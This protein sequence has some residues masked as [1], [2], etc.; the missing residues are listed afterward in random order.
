MAAPYEDEAASAPPTASWHQELIAPFG[1][2]LREQLPWQ[3]TS[4]LP[5]T[6]GQGVPMEDQER[7]LPSISPLRM[8]TDLRRKLGR[9]A[10]YNLRLLI[11][12][13]LHT[14]KTQLWR[15]LQ[16][17]SFGH[18]LPTTR[19]L[20]TVHLD[21]SSERSPDVV[22]VEAWDVVDADLTRSARNP[23]GLAF[24][25]HSS[26]GENGPRS[27]RTV[28]TLDVWRGAHAAVCLFDPRKRW[29]FAY[30]QRLLLEAPA[31]IPV[32]ILANFADL[33]DANAP[34]NGAASGAGAPAAG[35]A[36]GGGEQVVPWT[37][38]EQAAEEETA[39]SG[40][41]VVCVRGSAADCRGLEAVHAFIQLPYY[42][43]VRSSLERAQLDA[44][45]SLARAE[46][47]LHAMATGEPFQEDLHDFYP[48]AKTSSTPAPG[49]PAAALSPDA[50]KTR[51]RKHTPSDTPTPS[52]RPSATPTAPTPKLAPPPTPTPPPTTTPTPSL[53]TPLAIEAI[54]DSFF[55]GLDATPP[56]A[57]GPTPSSSTA[58]GATPQ[59][60]TPAAQSQAEEDDD[61][62]E[63]VDMLPL[64][65]D[66]DDE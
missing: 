60:G 62:D 31:H 38:V 16:G 6:C 34:A 13:D 18:D 22:K 2:W 63:M 4:Y 57:A 45:A 41:R 53:S 42:Q 49:T 23:S 55:D 28:A 3:L 46:A 11:R 20:G 51:R 39:R 44:D 25:H 35:G 24:S 1:V 52:S 47:H 59:R 48:A 37:E 10:T 32:L 61:E 43:M 27:P 26:P 14:G 50:T 56:A 36:A 30:A 7:Q 58:A 65:D 66:P 12:G 54:D 21:W 5:L 17:L 40:R 9:G 29:T 19:V 64:L 8:S 33:L 15:R